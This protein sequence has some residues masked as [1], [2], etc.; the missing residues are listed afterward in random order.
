MQ[1]PAA[2]E[3]PACPVC[4]GASFQTVLQGARDHVW[5]KPGLFALQRCAGC[6]LVM[7]RPRPTAAAL[8]FYYEGS[9][10]G[11]A[12][13]GMKS[14]QTLSWMGRRLAHYRLRVMAKVHRLGRADRLLDVGCS[15]GGFL[16]A[17]R[18][19]S[20]C[21][22]SGIDYDEGSIAQAMDRDVTEYR[23]G[24]LLSADYREGAFTVITFYE[25]LEHHAEPVATLARARELLE[26]GGVCVVEVPN[27][28]GFWR[29]VWR[30]F[31][32]PLLVPQHLFHFTPATLRRALET[33]GLRVEHQ[34]T[35]FFPLEGV[36][37]LATALARLL[38]T[39]PMGS[40]PTWRTPLD[41]LLLLVMA[42][43]FFAVEIPSQAVLHLL[44][45]SGHQTAIA[46]RE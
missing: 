35:M 5:R 12:D 4:D 27:F 42:V 29:R 16:R 20:G 33:A 36:A 6:E 24:E 18:E 41:I 46:R 43:L 30:T 3:A 13:G 32:M 34:Q 2:L 40:K 17:A 39:P 9:Y 21:A 31:W 14:F 1:A 22:T 45:A 37:S 44:G 19:A 28:G 38:R 8:G 26:P 10:S 25:S 7:T 15:Y 23:T 11:G